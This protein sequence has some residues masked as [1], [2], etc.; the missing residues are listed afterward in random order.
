MNIRSFRAKMIINILS[1]VIFA[2]ITLAVTSLVITY[3]A[4][5]DEINEKMPLKLDS[6]LAEMDIKLNAHASL[7]RSISSFTQ[8]SGNTV[9]R[10]MFLA[11]LEDLVNDNPSSFGLGIWYEPYKY[12]PSVKYFGPYVYKDKGKTVSTEEYEKA[13]YDY[14]NQEWYLIS[15]DK[16]MN[17]VT[18]STP[19]YDEVTGIIMTS[20][21]SPFF[22]RDGKFLGTSTGDLDI[23]ELQNIVKDIR[24]EKI[25][26][27]AFLLD[28]TGLYITNKHK[29]FVMKKKI[30]EDPDAEL[31]GA[32]KRIVS[33]KNGMAEIKLEGAAHLLYFKELKQTGWILCITV[34]KSMLYSPVRKMAVM[35]MLIAAI[36]IAI[37]IFISIYIAGKISTPVKAMS[38][39]A[40]KIAEG[41]FTERINIIQRDEIGNLANALNTSA[42]NLET[43]ISSIIT[44]SEN[45]SQAVNEIT[46]GNLNLSQR[47]T[48]QASA[49]EE[50]ASTI[51]ENT[52]TVERNAENSRNAQQLTQGGVE[53]SA[54]GSD[55][56]DVAINSINDISES[57]KKIS[58]IISVI[59]EIAF[60][61]NLLALN[62][63]VEAAR[64][65]DQGK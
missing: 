34:N 8:S 6:I 4:I 62:A 52:A 58:E 54:V 46:K 53:K 17:S 16:Q 21:V 35:T 43:L 44:T 57:S 48:E 2:I 60:Q 27:E 33:Q 30:T 15:K 29:E 1:I 10:E 11:Y 64:A 42:D 25:G 51:E 3:Y 5:N 7:A 28:S 41:N 61:T 13:S 22:D 65:G 59:N 14:H 36:S 24:D 45:L 23:V 26:L 37:S 12:R 50:I 39:F 63:A 38:A 20:A 47:T 49:L 19:F 18:W 31:A 32:G 56:A 9:S 55:L 40:E